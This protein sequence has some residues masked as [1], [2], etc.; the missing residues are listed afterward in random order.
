MQAAKSVL[1]MISTELD[2]SVKTEPCAEA[3][4]SQEENPTCYSVTIFTQHWKEIR[5]FYVEILDAKVV[6]ERPDRYCE[7]EMGG[8]PICLRKSELGEM[9]SYF[10]LYLSLRNR[11]RVLRELRKRG[12]IVTN[13][14]PYTNF[15]DPEGRV[16]KLS[17][18]KTVV[19]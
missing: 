3:E 14:G 4:V 13:V 7:M 1:K 11:D 2:L 6:S 17:D 9:V 19:A 18:A 8:I 16:I 15:R 10:H 5:D 12:I